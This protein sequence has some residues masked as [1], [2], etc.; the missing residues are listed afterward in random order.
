MRS[1]LCT[2]CGS[3]VGLSGGSIVFEDREGRYL[4]RQIAEVDDATAARAWTACPEK[5]LTFHFIATIF[6]LMRRTST[7][8][9]APTRS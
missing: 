9:L 4:P 5:S 2:R 6:I 1:E 3:C 8:I 7:N